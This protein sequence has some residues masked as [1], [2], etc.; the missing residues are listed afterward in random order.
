MKNK[1]FKVISLILVFTTILGCGGTQPSSSSQTNSVISNDDFISSSE[2][3]IKHTV[4]FVVDNDVI[5]TIEI[6]DNEIIKELPSLPEKNGYSGSWDYDFTPIKNDTVIHANYEL[7]TYNIYYHT[8]YGDVNP[9]NPI[10]YTLES[11]NLALYTPLNGEGLGKYFLGWYTTPTFENG[12][13]ISHIQS[14]SY[15]DIH[16]YAKWIACV[17]E[18]AEGF[19]IDYNTE[20]LPTLSMVVKNSRTIVTLSSM[21]T[22]SPNCTWTLSYDIEGIQDIRTKNVSVNDIGHNYYY[23]TVWYDENYNLVYLVDIYRLD[24]YSYAFISD[25]SIYVEETPVEETALIGRP[26]NPSKTGYTFVGWTVDGTSVVEFPYKAV[27]PVIFYALFTPNEYTISLDYDNENYENEKIKTTYDSLVNLPQP[28]KYGHTF[29]GWVHY[30]TNEYQESSFIYNYENSISLVATYALIK[31]NIYIDL[32]NDG[33]HDSVKEVIFGNSYTFEDANWDGHTFTGW[34]DGD[35]NYF[36]GSNYTHNNE[37]DMYISAN[38]NLNVYSIKYDLDGG[39]NS[40]EN[41][42]SY[43]YEDSFEFKNASKTGYRFNGWYLD[44]LYQ[45]RIYEIEYGSFGDLHLYASFAPNLYEY[46][47]NYE[48][49]D[50]VV[51]SVYYDSTF[52]I[53]QAQSKTGYTFINWIDQ[54]G[55]EYNPKEELEWHFT[56]NI[57]LTPVF[58]INTYEVTLLTSDENAATLSGAGTYEYNQIVTISVSLNDNYAFIGWFDLNDNLVSNSETYSFVV[59]LSDVTYKA[60]FYTLHYVIDGVKYKNNG[61]NFSVVGY[62]ESIS[63]EVNILSTFLDKNVVSIEDN[64][65]YDCDSLTSI[66]IPNSV[67]SIGDRAFYDCDS[68]T[69]IIIPN[70]VTSV[71]YIAFNGCRL[72]ENIYYEGS[73]EDWYNITFISN[74]SNPMFYAEHLFMLD[75]NNECY[76]VKNLEISS[77]ITKIGDYQ[78]AGFDNVTEIIIPNNVT[79]IGEGAFY[80]CK[81]LTSIMIAN[82]VASIGDFAFRNCSS[83]T[84]VTFEEDSQLTSIGKGV[85]EDCSSLTSITIPSSVTSIGDS[86]FRNCSSLIYIKIPNS[87][88]SIGS[89][90]FEGCSS[91]TNITI[92]DGVESIGSYAFSGCSSVSC[93]EIPISVSIIGNNAFYE[94]SSLY[95]FCDAKYKPSGWSST[96]NSYRPVYWG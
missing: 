72:L 75:E 92:S 90:A 71:G 81:S 14:G 87:V 54:Y 37:Q 88:K 70:S 39:D 40:S 91:L 52:I 56:Y 23:L 95:I 18:Y 73:M 80:S 36:D 29:T 65:F 85:F 2:E 26:D 62:T 96:W 10:T 94:C 78:F 24:M 12:T 47:V 19:V 9:L 86:A 11:E 63:N 50:V 93:I 17:V 64:A 6:E 57:E 34:T 53:P 41:P 42:N 46:K 21:I 60:K 48:N 28:T 33:E 1:L 67:T 5:E 27:A 49:G 43:T 38:W 79:S 84:T 76:E 7:L 13:K 4:T 15:G 59:G 61:S 8:D 22:V 55:N 51:N 69:S 16:L 32:D 35:G 25:N 82:S 45:E 3:I 44:E 66:T 77:T 31:N 20:S 58:E 89:Y 30:G 83:L 68:L 74:I